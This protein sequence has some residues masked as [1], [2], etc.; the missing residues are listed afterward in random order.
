MAA[1]TGVVVR[2]TRSLDPSVKVARIQADLQRDQMISDLISN[3]LATAAGIVTNPIVAGVAG[4][5]TIERIKDLVMENPDYNFLE[6]TSITAGYAGLQAAIT[7][8]MIAHG[9]GGAGG[10]ASIIKAAKD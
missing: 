10:I 9:F 7:A 8:G 2:K 5:W 1:L 6:R 4:Y 3:I